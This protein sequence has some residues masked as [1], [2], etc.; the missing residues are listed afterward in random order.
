MGNTVSSS[1]TL[2]EVMNDVNENLVSIMQKQVSAN[3]TTCSTNNTITLNFGSIIGC[4]ANIA[5][6]SNLNCNLQSTFQT[7]SSTSLSTLMQQAAQQS[8][9]AQATAAADVLSTSNVNSNTNENMSTYLTNLI[10]TNIT[11][12]TE[13]YCQAQG[14]INNSLT[15][16][17][18]TID[19]TSNP[20]AGLNLSQNAQL[21]VVGNCLTNQLQ[22]IINSAT[23]YQSSSQTGTA[24]S[25]GSAT[26]LA[27]VIDSIGNAIS[28]IISSISSVLDSP[29]IL[30]FVVVL[31]LIGLVVL[32]YKL[33]GGGGSGST[34]SVVY[35][36]QPQ[37]AV[38]ASPYPYPYY[39]QNEQYQQP[40]YPGGQSS[41]TSNTPY[42]Q[43]PTYGV[44]ANISNPQ[45]VQYT[46]PLQYP[47]PTI[48]QTVVNGLRSVITPEN[49]QAV[50][51]L[52]Q[53]YAPAVE[54]VAPVVA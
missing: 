22:N 1:T 41:N 26:G 5:Q 45:P 13:S 29:A 38:P 51:N 17:V 19:C 9:V 30:I 46:Q 44:S 53:A 52:A 54:R 28:K 50:S 39:G 25:S 10:Q 23:T 37:S 35:A 32:F 11:S 42:V 24:S 43:P 18:G 48:G 2:T 6:T 4:S 31:I 12:D 16:N 27:G 20:S 3:S 7:N 33:F 49:I 40:T 47:P 21:V 15:L 8:A 34:G 36:Q 14:T